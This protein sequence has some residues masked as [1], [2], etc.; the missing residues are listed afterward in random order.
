MILI[1]HR[2]NTHGPI[3]KKEN[4]ITHIN[5]ALNYRFHVEIDVW[6]IGQKIYLGHDRPQHEISKSFLHNKKFFCHA[7]NIQ[8][9]IY[10]AGTNL[11]YFWHEDDRYA[12]TSEGFILAHPKHILKSPVSTYNKIICMSP[13][14][15]ENLKLEPH[16]S[17]YGICSDY[18]F[19]F[20]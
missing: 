20:L 3:T 1:S 9:L 19:K 10:L 8:A 2:G 13:E 5:S 16:N 14:N 15:I 12:I 7:K 17:F 11:N 18:I 6:K 4:T